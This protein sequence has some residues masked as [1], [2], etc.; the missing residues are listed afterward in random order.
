MRFNNDDRYYE[1]PR[2]NYPFVRESR[3][4]LEYGIAVSVLVRI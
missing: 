1:R 3:I 4:F 2:R